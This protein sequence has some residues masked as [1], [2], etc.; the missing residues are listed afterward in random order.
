M[1]DG[2][3]ADCR[4]PRC[5][6]GVVD[7]G[8]ECD[9][10]NTASCDGCSFD[11]RTEAALA[12]A[13]ANGVPDVCD[14]C[15]AFSGDPLCPPRPLVG[16]SAAELVRFA[17]GADKFLEPENPATGLGPVFNGTRCA[18]CHSQPTNGGS[19]GRNVTRIG[20][21]AS[22][23]FGFDPLAAYGGPVIQEHGIATGACAVP[24][25]VVPPQAT[26]VGRRN[27]PA[28][29]GAGLLEAIPE[30]EIRVFADRSR[31]KH[32]GI[33]GTMNV[34]DP[35]ARQ[36]GRF[37]WKAQLASLHDFAVDAYVEEIGITSPL[38]KID[39]LPQGAPAACD[40]AGDP[41]D[42]GS[43]VAAFTDFMAL[44]APPPTPRRP[45]PD[46]RRGK[47]VFR[48]LGCDRCHTDK[49]RTATNFPVAALRGKRVFAYTDLLIHDMGPGLA[50]GIVQ[51][52]ASGSEFRTAPLWGARYSAPYLHDG[53]AATLVDAIAAHGGEAQAAR[54]RFSLL[55][56]ADQ[57]RLIAFLNAL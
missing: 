56:P 23:G 5:G 39:P 21:L 16:L 17:H 35:G 3:R 27:T 37:G 20:A 22:N 11:C 25:E 8:E 41:E 40:P 2:C 29:F 43:D 49:Y 9:D 54:D 33:R 28:L 19:S 42:D 38:A 7:A 31:R 50:D 26:F 46:A 51:G 13:D 36:I 44:L 53:R 4:L 32:D 47:H 10:G 34:P 12:D 14:A 1:P 6:D 24:G 48:K 18:E 30:A 55:T 57:T 45:S 15:R 52:F